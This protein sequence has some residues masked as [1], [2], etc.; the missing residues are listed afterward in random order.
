MNE[1]DFLK[2]MRSSAP[3][4]SAEEITRSRT[5][6]RSAIASH[7]E[8]K[9][10]KGQFRLGKHQIVLGLIALVVVPSGLAVAGVFEKQ[11]A[12]GPPTSNEIS[13]GGA[14]GPEACPDATAAFQKAGVSPI[15]AYP[16]G[17][18]CPSPEEIDELI[19]VQLRR[20]ADT[21]RGER[22]PRILRSR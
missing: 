13:P 5:K 18:P 16:V 1:I 20:G 11:I 19:R 12:E 7:P 8:G 21:K 15:T 6:L 17:E 3:G 14:V 10:D 22:E 2:G 4:A 9:T